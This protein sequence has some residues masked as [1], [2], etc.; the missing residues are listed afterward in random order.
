MPLAELPHV[1]VLEA[2]VGQPPVSGV[3]GDLLDGIAA[4]TQDSL[5]AFDEG[6]DGAVHSVA[7]PASFSSSSMEGAWSTPFDPE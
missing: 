2:V 7:M 4:V 1:F 5:L 3:A 6:G